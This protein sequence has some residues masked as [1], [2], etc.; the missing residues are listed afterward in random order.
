MIG[1]TIKALLVSDVTLTAL[2]P[3]T[4]IFPY[5]MNED[6]PLPAIV[7]TIDQLIAD[8]N[9]TAWANDSVAFTVRSFHS[10][11]ALLQPIVSA[12]RGA[13]ELK[14]TGS[15]TQDINKIVLSDFQEGYDPVGVFFN[16]LTFKVT[17][18]SY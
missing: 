8:Y 1:K 4:K 3:A 7:Y 9:K 6:T 17:V 12:V 2:V 5:V 16:Y 10:D 14:Y 11:Y 13:I 18:N 15:G